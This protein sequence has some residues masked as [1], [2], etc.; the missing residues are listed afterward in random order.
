MTAEDEVD[1]VIDFEIRVVWQSD[2]FVKM[3]TV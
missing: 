2:I 3:I 1:R